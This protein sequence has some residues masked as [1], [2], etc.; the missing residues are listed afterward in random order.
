MVKGML[1]ERNKLKAVYIGAEADLV[2]NDIVETSGL[3]RNISKRFE[4]RGTKG[5]C[6]I[7]KCNRKI[8]N[9]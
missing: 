9:S 7:R 1:N 2:L 6:R 4:N 5:N 8:C 3:G